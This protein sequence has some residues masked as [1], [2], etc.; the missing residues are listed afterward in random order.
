M[1]QELLIAIGLRNSTVHYHPFASTA[2]WWLIQL[3]EFFNV[4]DYPIAGYEMP[5][6]IAELHVHTWSSS[7]SYAKSSQK[8]EGSDRVVVDLWL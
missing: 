7:I 8:A 3:V 6:T 1:F 2:D 5:R 4:V